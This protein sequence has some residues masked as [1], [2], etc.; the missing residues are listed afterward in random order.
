MKWW[1]H[2]F[3]LLVVRP[4]SCLH[5]SLIQASMVAIRGNKLQFPQLDCNGIRETRRML[6]TRQP[7]THHRHLYLG[8]EFDDVWVTCVPITISITV[9]FILDWTLYWVSSKLVKET[10]AS[11]E[12]LCHHARA[13][14]KPRNMR[15]RRATAHWPLSPKFHFKETCDLEPHRT[16]PYVCGSHTAAVFGLHGSGRNLWW[17]FYVL[18]HSCS[19][20]KLS[21]FIVAYVLECRIR[22]EIV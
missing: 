12:R 7:R 2:I 6:N 22:G 17:M 15:C 8:I 10:A 18:L 9:H 21:I 5:S 3:L 1:M 4:T 14:R 16:I 11:F 19:L 13:A 20:Y